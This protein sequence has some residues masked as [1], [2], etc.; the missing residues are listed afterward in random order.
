MTTTKYMMSAGLAFSEQSDL[1]KLRKKA[2]KGWIVKHFKF[3]GY[4]LEKGPAED[5]IFSIDY[6]DLKEEDSQEYF[7]IFEMSGWNH[8][9][10]DAGM[11]LFRALPDT[12]P[13]YS[14]KEST[15]DKHVR[16]GKPIFPIAFICTLVTIISYLLSQVD[17]NVMRSSF[18]MLFLISIVI[19]TPAL[20][21]LGAVLF[22]MWKEKRL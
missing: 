11:H 19:T 13:I 17:S 9:C 1:R 2:A 22:H 12:K 6:R 18:E 4:E 20:M 16:L 5:V 8:V 10:S 3:A 7:E 21:T 15:I 14:D